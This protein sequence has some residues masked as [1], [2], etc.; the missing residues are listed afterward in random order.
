MSDDAATTPPPPHRRPTRCPH[1]PT[2]R[3]SSYGLLL[4][5]A[6]ALTRNGFPR[7]ARTDWARLM[8]AL[9]RFLYQQKETL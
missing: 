5:I 3:R 2:T 6:D 9:G 4:D 1:R 7:P 8:T